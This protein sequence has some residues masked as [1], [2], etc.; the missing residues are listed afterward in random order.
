MNRPYLI[1]ILLSILFTAS[2]AGGCRKTIELEL[3]STYAR[4]VVEGNITDQMKAHRV[5]LTLSAD[6]FTNQPAPPV[7]G[8]T[9]EISDGDQVYLL[10]EVSPGVYETA[11]TVQGVPGKSYT[12][13]IKGVDIDQ[14]GDPEEYFATDILKPV[15]ML[16]SVV[17]EEQNPLSSPPLYKISGWGQEPPTPDDCYQWL[18]Y[19]NGVLKTDTLS[20]TLFADDTF[21]NGSY[22]PGLPMFFDV[23]ASPGDTIL[24]ETRSLTREY[25]TFIV[26]LMLETAW[27]Q[28]GGSGPPANIIGNVSNGAIGYF[29]AHAVSHIS[30]IVP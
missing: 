17:V 26:T 30:A 22:L 7:T 29:S 28:G 18:Y 3:D 13:T 15:M 5:V 23:K 25:Y 12:L 19:L 8:A 11:P 21:V 9:L 24:V 20:N 27:N 16:D 14:D 1:P 6:F 4:L 10:T 2:L